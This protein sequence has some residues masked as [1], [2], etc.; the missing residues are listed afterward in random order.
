MTD[1]LERARRLLDDLR[2]DALLVTAK[3][4]VRYLSGFR[5]EDA[6]LLV[7]RQTALIATDS[8]FWA[9]VAEE[10][11]GFG[12]EKTEKLLEDTLKALARDLGARA[13][14]GFQGGQT[15]YAD[16]RRLRRLHEGRLRDVGARVARLRMVKSPAELETMRRA[17]A[18]AD[19]ALEAVAA[20]GLVGR[21]E[22]EVAWQIET[23]MHQRGAEGPAFETIVAAGERAALAHAIP[24]GRR[25]GRGELVVIDAG[26]RVDG[27]CSD[28]TRT[29]AA[30]TAGARQRSVYELVL[31]AQLAGLA[32]VRPGVDGRAVDAACR[33]II[34]AAGH[35][36]HFGHG[37]GHGVGL[38]VHEGPRLGR[39]VGDRLEAGMVHTVEPGVYI[40]GELGVRIED[41]VVVT[42]AGCERLTLLPKELRVVG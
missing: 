20:T 32:A 42:P 10:V 14:L 19:A 30:G 7:G 28:I 4:D 11:A 35:A 26:A 33:Q 25:I 39:T 27:Y 37:T 24:G 38:E 8:R 22:A 6:W 29:L 40:E 1:R 15:T 2:L 36:D 23:E 13:A 3:A 9:Q 31:Q 41:T 16:Y 12:L 34:E 18:V 5:G 17:A 21:T